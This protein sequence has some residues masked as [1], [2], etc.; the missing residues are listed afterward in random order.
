MSGSSGDARWWNEFAHELKGA[1]SNEVPAWIGSMFLHM[2]LII[3][4]GTLFM[5][6][7]PKPVVAT[8]EAFVAPEEKKA[9]LEIRK[10][11]FLLRP[12]ELPNVGSVRTAGVEVEVSTALKVAE[13]IELP[14]RPPQTR[15][16]TEVRVP[17]LEDLITA[18][19]KG[20]RIQ[21]KGIAGDGATGTLGALDRITQEILLSLE[22]GPTLVV[23]FFDQSGS[24][25]IQREAVAERFDR[26]YKELGLSKAVAPKGPTDRPLLS[27][28]VAFG[29]D[30]TFLTDKPTDDINLI[31]SAV[32]SIPN[33][34]SGVEMTF[35]AIGAAAQK[36]ENFR[37]SQPRRRV[38]MVVFTDEVGEDE[39]RLEDCVAV[40]KRNQMPVF[41][42]G[43]PAPFGRP[44]IEIKYVDPDP[45]YDQSVQWIPVRQG[46]ETFLPEQVQLN[47]SGKA[48]RDDGMYRLDSGFG[49]YCLT[50][51]CYETGGIFFAVHGNRERIDGFVTS[52]ETP[53][54]Q[55][56]LNYFF[57]PLVMK[58]YRPDYLPTQ[59]YVKSVSKNKAKMALVEAAKQSIVDPMQNPVLVF[60]KTG[61]DDSSMK[62]ALDEA[63]KKA[64]ILGP[65]IDNLYTII[66]AGEKDREKLVEPR[67]RAGF[68]LAYGRV[69]AVK[70]RTE[71]Y[72]QMLA[73]A[74]GGMKLADPKTN[75]LTL[76]PVDEVSSNS[77]LDKMGKLA[78]ELLERVAQE[79]RGT[80]WA[81]MAEAELNDPI[82]WKWKES[83]DPPPPPPSARPPQVPVANNGN[84]MN[85]PQP[86]RRETP[87]PMRQNVKL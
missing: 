53:V 83:Y 3:G 7:I 15:M 75:V 46:A 20:T 42:V 50:R 16:L 47:F 41:V 66:K 29:K 81:M 54:F 86:P 1:F 56:R 82:G 67:W 70:V 11:E 80:P 6:P 43:V 38:M 8:L 32:A 77:Q 14:R 78:R 31:R 18:P 30:I 79:H 72:N 76:V 21:I 48:N 35:T 19:N 12:S 55:A 84:N 51:L 34:D 9:P 44:N 28:V 59:D 17:L 27:S 57:D 63:Q 26:I 58:P 40:C 4:L 87:K 36:Y 23:W 25:Q 10:Q 45:N 71:A 5:P 73:R 52:R 62:A 2:L 68:D 69:L 74:K 39:N 85:R 22:R 37:F 61:E 33:D 64:A 13:S 24:M 65:R 49:P 60:R